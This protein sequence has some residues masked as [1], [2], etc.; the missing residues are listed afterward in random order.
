[1][2]KRITSI[3]ENKNKHTYVV[4]FGLDVLTLSEDA[5]TD[6]Y[7]YVNKEI[8]DDE[9][10]K[11]KKSSETEKI[12]MYALSLA[13][14]GCYSS[15]EIRE[16]IKK[17]LPEGENPSSI[18]SRLKKNNLLDDTNFA[19]QYKEE[20]EAALYGRLRIKDDLL[21]KK[22]LSSEIVESLEFLNEEENAAKFASMIEGRYDS[23]PLNEKKR[24]ALNALMVRGFSK[25]DSLKAISNYKENKS[26]SEAKLKR[27]YESLKRKFSGKYSDYETKRRIYQTLLR[28]GYTNEEI[29]GIMEDRDYDD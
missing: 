19:K 17:K 28:K 1:M 9:F 26:L 27:E 12:Y 10:N 11:L 4:S 15:Y 14:K 3:V 23:L 16:K 5:F 8:S 7:L 24:K 20:K 2:G 22:M 29:K 21:H 25:A 18:I 6:H 13:I